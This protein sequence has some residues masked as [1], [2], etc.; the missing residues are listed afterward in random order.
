MVAESGRQRCKLRGDSWRQEKK[1][2]RKTGESWMRAKLLRYLY[3]VYRTYD[4]I[5]TIDTIASDKVSYTQS[6]IEVASSA[7][8]NLPCS[9][10]HHSVHILGGK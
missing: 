7:N 8:N 5:I 6:F 10:R 3:T 9:A 1:K 2:K 4:T